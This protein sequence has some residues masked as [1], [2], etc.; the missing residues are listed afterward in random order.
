MTR[1]Y[2]CTFENIVVDANYDRRTASVPYYGHQGIS[3]GRGRDNLLSG[4]SVLAPLVRWGRGGK[5][6]NK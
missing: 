1:T 3:F 5:R 2:F 6:V 4:F